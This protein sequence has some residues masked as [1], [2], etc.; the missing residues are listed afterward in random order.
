MLS[1]TPSKSGVDLVIE[2]QESRQCEIC[3]G[4]NWNTPRQSSHGITSKC[5]SFSTLFHSAGNG[6]NTCQILSE[7]VRAFYLTKDAQET[8]FVLVM[9]VG[10]EQPLH[11]GLPAVYRDRLDNTNIYVRLELRGSSLFL[12]QGKGTSQPP[13]MIMPAS[14]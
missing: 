5:T 9:G 13:L 10:L 8:Q 12:Y 14:S 6:C 2:R 11:E 7:A 3:I 1:A 4:F